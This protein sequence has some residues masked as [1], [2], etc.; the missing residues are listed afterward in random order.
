MGKVERSVSQLEPTTNP[1]NPSE[2]PAPPQEPPAPRK[3][4]LLRRLLRWGGIALLVLVLIGVTFWSILAID[5]SDLS[6]RPPRH[7]AA[8]LYGVAALAAILFI[9]PRKFGALAVALMF[10]GTLIWFFSL[11]ATNDREWTPDVAHAPTIEIVGDRMTVHNLRNFD[12]RSE[13]DFT[14]RWEDRTYDLSQLRGIDV[15]LVYWGSP[16]IAHGMVAFDFGNDNYLDV[17]IETRKEKHESYSAIEGFFRQYELIYIFADER[18]VVRLRTNFRKEDVYL[19]HTIVKPTGARKILMAYVDQANSLAARPQFYNAL[20]SNCVSNIVYNARAANPGAR[21]T[22]DTILSGYAARQ[23]YRH[24]RIDRSLPFEELQK[25]SHVND[26]AQRA[27]DAPDFSR[28]IRVGLP[29]P[30]PQ[31]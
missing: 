19:Y 8:A 3:R 2:A 24:G 4:S 30:P 14:P 22:W 29:V 12:Y 26:A 13:T 1:A 10:A 9:R 20:T 27:G 31:N 18:D 21:L 17:S 16:A 5:L 15:M 7:V 28:L 6:I 25:R 23:M 11:K